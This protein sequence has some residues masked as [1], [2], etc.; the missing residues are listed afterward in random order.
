MKRALRITTNVLI[1]FVSFCLAISI[2]VAALYIAFIVWFRNACSMIENY[3]NFVA[4]GEVET[5]TYDIDSADSLW[6]FPP[7][8]TVEKHID[9]INAIPNVKIINDTEYKIEITA[10]TELLNATNVIVKENFAYIDCSDS[11]YGV[12]PEDVWGK[13][14][15]GV[16]IDCTKMDIVVHAPVSYLDSKS[17]GINLDFD[18][19]KAES[20][21]I[22]VGSSNGTVYNIDTEEL[23]LSAVGTSNIKIAGNV[24]DTAEI[25]LLHDSRIN[26][27]DMRVKHY[28]VYVSRTFGGF[29]CVFANKPYIVKIEPYILVIVTLVDAIAFLPII[30]WLALDVDLIVIRKLFLSDNTTK[31]KKGKSPPTAQ[32]TIL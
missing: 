2:A 12:M 8:L 31:K 10:N 30:F 4:H 20:V 22:N 5:K 7:F 17:T 23:Y 11:I 15:L 16:D 19:A 21:Y 14:F 32:S 3:T 13:E 6:L 28:D 29:S 27:M 18:V 9:F 26:A 1:G 24:A 25:Y